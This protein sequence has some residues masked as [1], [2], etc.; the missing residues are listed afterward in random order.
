MI[1]T[2]RN[3]N[4]PILVGPLHYYHSQE[5]IKAPLR[6]G[7]VQ[8]V[9]IFCLFDIQILHSFLHAR[10]LRRSMRVRQHADVINI[11]WH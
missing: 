6:Y 3:I 7:I 8:Q 9:Y 4:I 10:R 11:Y 5:D 1:Y 2:H